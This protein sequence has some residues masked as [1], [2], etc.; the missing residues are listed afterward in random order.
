MKKSFVVLLLFLCFGLYCY[1]CYVQIEDVRG[2]DEHVETYIGV[3]D[4][5]KETGHTVKFMYRDEEVYNA[6]EVTDDGLVTE[7]SL[8][9]YHPAWYSDNFDRIIYWATKNYKMENGSMI[10]EYDRWDFDNDTVS[11]DMTLYPVVNGFVCIH[12]KD[13]NGNVIDGYCEY[14]ASDEL[15]WITSSYGVKE[16]CFK[17]EF[18]VVPDT[19]YDFLGWAFSDS[20]CGDQMY[21]LQ[22]DGTY[23]SFSNLM[24]DENG[25]DVR[26]LF[27]DKPVYIQVDIIDCCEFYAEY[28][29]SNNQ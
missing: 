7:P 17:I 13:N 1:Y 10:T 2:A 26:Y 28:D 14:P 11:E 3:R 9:G 25:R 20:D 22:E 24:F 5:P 16:L 29:F 18:P 8:D 6:Q 19:G 23:K 4:E 12:F 27:K 15:V 21:E